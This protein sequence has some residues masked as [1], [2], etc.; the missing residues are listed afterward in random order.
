MNRGHIRHKLVH[1]S[2]RKRLNSEKLKKDQED[3]H[4]REVKE[5][6]KDEHSELYEDHNSIG[7]PDDYS[8]MTSHDRVL[9][10]NNLIKS[11]NI[12]RS[13]QVEIEPNYRR[14]IVNP[15]EETKLFKTERRVGKVGVMFVGMCGRSSSLIISSIFANK[16]GI[17]YFSRDGRQV[18][19]FQ[20]CVTQTGYAT[21]G[22]SNGKSVDVPIRSIVPLL[23]PKLIVCGGWE[24]SPKTC[25]MAVAQTHVLEFDLQ[26]QLRKPLRAV[27]SKPGI[28]RP[29]VH[30]I[31]VKSKDVMDGKW[32]NQYCVEQVGKDIES[33]KE[34]HELDQVIVLYCGPEPQSSTDSLETLQKRIR[35]DDRKLC[36]SIMYAYA[37]IQ[38]GCSFISVDHE[39]RDLGILQ[40]AMQK[41]IIFSS[42]SSQ[43]ED[44]DTNTLC[45]CVRDTTS[46]TS[47]TNMI[48]YPYIN[49]V[50]SRPNFIPTYNNALH[51]ITRT[52]EYGLFHSSTQHQSLILKSPL[53]K[54]ACIIDQIVLLELS[55]RILWKKQEQ[56]TYHSFIPSESMLSMK[57]NSKWRLSWK[58]EFLQITMSVLGLM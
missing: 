9:I 49:G 20:G 16:L 50:Q 10:K 47:Q 32:S 41:Q 5:E 19:S 54:V 35:E 23:D 31:E 40:W 43:Q 22:H 51:T 26:R 34:E 44:L 55:R 52:H 1:K 2:A 56:D 12:S 13:I 3:T 39:F 21:I 15:H 24:I 58:H 48:L 27:K 30:R 53:Y 4:I 11:R 14:I 29:L 38:A 57:I 45:G 42:V 36:P 25:G 8:V 7:I 46:N 17:Q 18:S 37:A 6:I 33:F 28:Y